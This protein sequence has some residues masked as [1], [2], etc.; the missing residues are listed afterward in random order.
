MK[1]YTFTAD[2]PS[3]ALQKAQNACGKDALVVNTKMIRKKSFTQEGLY[4]VVVAVE[5]DKSIEDKKPTLDKKIQKDL[6]KVVSTT[7]K[8]DSL[9][10]E[11]K[12]ESIASKEIKK[13]E[14]SILNVNA[15]LK[16]LQELFLEAQKQK[17]IA[18]PPEFS[19]I[20]HKL[21]LSKINISDINEIVGESIKYMPTYM[22]SSPETIE[23]YFKVLLKKLIPIRKEQKL[24]KQK[25]MMFVGPTGVGKTTTLAKLAARYSILEYNY[26]V[27]II[28]LDTYRIGAVEQLYQYAKMMKLPIEDVIGVDDF[29]EAMHRFSNLDIILIDSVGSS[30][31]D[32]E[33]LKRLKEFVDNSNINIEMNLVVSANAKYEDLEEIYNSFKFL[34]LK[35][36]IVTKFDESKKFGNIFSLVKKIKLPLNYFSVGQEVPDDLRV[37]S[38]GF[39]VDCLFEGFKR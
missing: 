28:T 18:I 31:Y 32:K 3:K 24:K 7:S 4:E 20:Y 36:M 8:I 23:R 29:K 16:E 11:Q 33:K 30:Q 27:G 5:D 9:S 15:R 19:E 35:N 17:E 39:L 37:A 6:N 13:L 25:I 1:L 34:D 21:K 14:E 10:I 22:K 38:S 26:K 12:D 2:S